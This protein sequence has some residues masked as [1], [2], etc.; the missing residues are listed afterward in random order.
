MAILR[1]KLVERLL[2]V[3]GLVCLGYYGYVSAESA[4]YQA[5]ETR[6]LDAILASAS[7]DPG[8]ATT[9]WVTPP[10]AATPAPAPRPRPE[11]A[12]TLGRLELPRLGVS[13]IVRAGSAAR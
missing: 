11:T 5:Y 7:T 12:A 2:L 10:A 1:L 4:L 6:E 13:A 9:V 8:S 3:I